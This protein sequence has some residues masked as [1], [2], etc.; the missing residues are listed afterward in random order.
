M[1]FVFVSMVLGYGLALVYQYNKK[2]A[3]YEGEYINLSTADN[4]LREPLLRN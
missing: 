1:T 3:D 4:E 2:E